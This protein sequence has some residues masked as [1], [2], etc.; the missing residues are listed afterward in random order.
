MVHARGVMWLLMASHWFC[1]YVV[2]QGL[3]Q[4]VA[5]IAAQRGLAPAQQARPSLRRGP[6]SLNPTI[7]N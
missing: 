2:R 5:L 7:P 3:P 4:L 1:G 6:L